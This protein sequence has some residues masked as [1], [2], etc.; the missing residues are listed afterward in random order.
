[1]C[2]NSHDVLNALMQACF[3]GTLCV[4]ENECIICIVSNVGAALRLPGVNVADAAVAAS[5]ALPSVGRGL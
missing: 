3:V 1:M 4:S 2:N 5:A